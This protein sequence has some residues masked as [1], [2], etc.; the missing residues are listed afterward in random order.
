MLWIFKNNLYIKNG[1]FFHH[2][3]LRILKAQ[4]KNFRR[5]ML[6][7]EIK[8]TL[9][10]TEKE[11]KTLLSAINETLSINLSVKKE[12]ER[13][14][15]VFTNF[16]KN[17]PWEKTE[18]QYLNFKEISF[19][20][21]I[22]GNREI[23]FIFHCFNVLEPNSFEYYSKYLGFDDGETTNKTRVDINVGCLS[24]TIHTSPISTLQHEMEHL[25]QYYVGGNTL[26][27]H[28]SSYKNA[29]HILTHNQSDLA[30]EIYDIAFLIYTHTDFEQDAFVNQLYRR[31][32][33]DDNKK[34]EIIKKSPAF[35][36]FKI[37]QNKIKYIKN[38]REKYESILKKTFGLKYDSF[39]SNITKANKRFIK[40]I[41]KVITLYDDETIENGGIIDFFDLSDDYRY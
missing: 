30:Q 34:I 19:T 15:D 5:I 35:R 1:D 22:F 33:S 11:K 32:K 4:W 36:Y 17:T 24:G 27:L 16:F 41:G 7:N 2:F 13:I 18:K 25:Y 20:E 39:V 10:L 23:T 6:M 29:L 3:L 37:G 26:S 9:K 14:Y 28:N 40:K 31:L 8:K 12:T 21:K 38:N